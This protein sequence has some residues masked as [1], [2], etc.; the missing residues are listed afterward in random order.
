MLCFEDN[1]NLFRIAIF[2][3]FIVAWFIFHRNVKE[4]ENFSSNISSGSHK[5]H[6][7][8]DLFYS[9]TVVEDVSQS[10]CSNFL[11]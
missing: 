6:I 5:F 11:V 7:C 3:V 8:N 2:N 1:K 10:D 4:F 9:L